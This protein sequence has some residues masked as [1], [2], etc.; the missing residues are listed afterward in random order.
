MDRLPLNLICGIGYLSNTKIVELVT[1]FTARPNKY[2]IMLEHKIL[3]KVLKS[4][5]PECLNDDL[6][7]T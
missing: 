4:F 3:W 7:L 6:E 5:T 2:W 1:F